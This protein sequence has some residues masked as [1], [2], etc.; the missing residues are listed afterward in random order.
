MDISNLNYDD[1]NEV[2]QNDDNNIQVEEPVVNE[3]IE[4]NEEEDILETFLKTQGISDMHK[5]MFEDED[6]TEIERDW[7]ELSK[8]E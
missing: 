4:E 2:I 3:K 1:D 6:G 8:S 5:I 7:N